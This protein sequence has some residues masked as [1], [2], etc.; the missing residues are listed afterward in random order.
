MSLAM[1]PNEVNTEVQY[2]CKVRH[3]AVIFLYTEVLDMR[4]NITEIVFILDRSGS[5][6][7][8]EA[9]TIGGFNSMIEKQKKREGRGIDL[10]CSL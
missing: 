4:K 10:Y 1:R 3:Q 7:G 6:S 9:D 5:M 2:D 8:L